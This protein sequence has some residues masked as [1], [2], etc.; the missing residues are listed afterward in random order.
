MERTTQTIYAATGE[1]FA[2]DTTQTGTTSIK[3]MSALPDDRLLVLERDVATDGVSLIPWV[4][5]LDPAACDKDRLCDTLVAKVEIPEIS[6]ADFE[7]LAQLTDDL[8]LIVS[9]DKIGNDHR[10]VF[11]LLRITAT[12]TDQPSGD[13]GEK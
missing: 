8:F 6:D 11:G 12:Q 10:S 2:Y 7:G 13:T 5:M 1:S 9:D 4:R 3:A